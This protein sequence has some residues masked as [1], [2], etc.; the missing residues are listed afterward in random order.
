[1][2]QPVDASQRL[3]PPVTAALLVAALI[4]AAWVIEMRPLQLV[5][6]LGK[7]LVFLEG[8]LHP[9]FGRL[10]TYL[11][12]CLE[13]LALALW[14]TFLGAALGV[15]LGFL[16]ARNVTPHPVVYHLARRVM[17]VFRAVNEM[18]L[19]LMFV[20]A[21]GLG[22]FAG[23]MALAIHS[24]GILGKLL[25]E[26]VES[27]DEGQVEGVAAAGTHKLLVIAF[28]IVP[29]VIPNYLSYVLL[30]FESDVRSAT[31]VGMVGGGGI[32]F[33]LWESLRSFQDSEASTIIL[34]IT[35]LVMVID[36]VS[37][38]LRKQFI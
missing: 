37:S 16:G 26:T 25:S 3:A 38:R 27:I 17:D 5:T 21:V 7:A 33:Y 2:A 23:M 22:P 9:S 24:G 4:W 30:R 18:V 11:K 34:L 15:P 36:F 29:Q 13:T 14:G 20:A 6:D 1:V 35:G 32:G 31:V 8:F 28:G 19:A 10:E 12:A